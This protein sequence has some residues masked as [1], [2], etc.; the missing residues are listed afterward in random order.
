M[1]PINVIH[2]KPRANKPYVLLPIG[3]FCNVELQ[4]A[5]EGT[6]INF[7]QGSTCWTMILLSKVVI[8]VKSALFSFLVHSLYNRK[9][10]IFEKLRQWEEEC[11]QQGIGTLGFDH[12]KAMLIEVQ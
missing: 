6:A 9:M 8:P 3:A 2:P 1:A 11:R 12:E 5:R 7:W 10:T 4:N